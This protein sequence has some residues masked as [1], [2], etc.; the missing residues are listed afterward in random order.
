MTCETWTHHSHSQRLKSSRVNWSSSTG[1]LEGVPVLR[2]VAASP[3]PCPWACSLLV[4]LLASCRL[5]RLPHGPRHHDG[6]AAPECKRVLDLLGGRGQ[7]W[8]LQ[9]PGRH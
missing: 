5:L 3:L 7:T 8:C 9:V 2:L 6:A 1:W 4:Q